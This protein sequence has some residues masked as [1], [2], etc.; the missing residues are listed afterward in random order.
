MRFAL[1]S[2]EVA[3]TKRHQEPELRLGRREVAVTLQ[4]VVEKLHAVLRQRVAGTRTLAKQRHDS[5]RQS[6]RGRVERAE[7]HRRELRQAPRR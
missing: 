2:L 7:T 5:T 3:E 4:K 1:I 6:A